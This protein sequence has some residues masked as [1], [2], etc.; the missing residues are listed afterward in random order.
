MDRFERILTLHNLLQSR[1]YPVSATDLAHQLGCKQKTLKQT[2]ADMRS[3]LGAPIE[4]ERKRNGYYY[5]RR[6]AEHPY[7]LPGLWFNASELYAL[8]ISERLLA[9]AQPGLLEDY[10]A[11]L[12]GRIEELLGNEQLIREDIRARVR[13]LPMAARLSLVKTG[14]FAQVADALM[15]RRRLDLTYHGRERDE[16]TQRITSPQR[17]VHYRDN[18]HL[19]AW[20]HRRKGLRNFALDRVLSAQVLPEDAKEV[21]AKELDRHFATA[22]GI[23][24]GEPDKTAVLRFTPKRARWV[25]DEQWH[26]KQEFVFLADGRYELRLPYRD[27]RELIMAILKYGPDVEVVSPKELRDQVTERLAAA[28]WRYKKTS[29]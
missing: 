8:L 2:I 27:P 24:G 6:D 29:A 14:Q 13:I 5:D 20:C 17:L 4:Y 25:A 3:H 1:R 10:I 23:F 19:D 21:P 22:Y 16:E 15:R 26:P 18:W 11:P 28:L 9:E 12:T 7:E